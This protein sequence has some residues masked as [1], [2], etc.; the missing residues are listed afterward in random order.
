MCQHMIGYIQA[1]EDMT[2]RFAIVATNFM[3][4]TEI[5]SIYFAIFYMYEFQTIGI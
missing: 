5:H 2:I 3:L 4:S 1:Q